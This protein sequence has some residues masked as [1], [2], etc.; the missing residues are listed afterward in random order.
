MKFQTLNK[1]TLAISA[2][3]LAGSQASMVHA[4][5]G[6]HSGIAAPPK[7]TP[8]TG[9]YPL[10]PPGGWDGVVDSIDKQ[11][12]NDKKE[13]ESSQARVNQLSH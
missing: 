1:L 10:P 6:D 9:S 5:D 13:L 4:V 3:L 11:I 2:I 7:F 12:E 8:S